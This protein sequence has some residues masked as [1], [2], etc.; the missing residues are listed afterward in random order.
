MSLYLAL[1]TNE[2]VATLYMFSVTMFFF[3]VGFIVDA[4]T[5]GE[6]RIIVITA[7]RDQVVQE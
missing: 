1:F 4:I 7:E 3:G 6:T 2:S 5:K